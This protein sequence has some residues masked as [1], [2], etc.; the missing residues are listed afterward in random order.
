MHTL[1]HADA[2]RARR[3]RHG[4]LLDRALHRGAHLQPVRHRQ[5]AQLADR[6]TDSEASAPLAQRLV[7]RALQVGQSAHLV[8]H[9][10]PAHHCRAELE[11]HHGHPGAS[12]R[13]RH[14][15]AAESVRNDAR[16]E[17]RHH[18][19]RHSHGVHAAALV[20]QEG[21][22]ARIRLHNVQLNRRDLLV[23]VAVSP[24]SQANRAHS[25]QPGI[26]VQMVLVPLRVVCVL[27][28][29]AHRVRL[30]ACA[31]LD[32]SRPRRHS[33]HSRRALLRH[34]DAHAAQVR[35]DSADAFERLQMVASV[36]ALA[37]AAG[38]LDEPAELLWQECGHHSRVAN[39]SGQQHRRP[40]SQS[41]G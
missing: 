35:H 11:H 6:R 22:A 26:R 18:R 4:P 27:R 17:H 21:H 28:L 15:L 32:R 37:A 3:R 7:P 16:L 10:L 41:G 25:W 1:V 31:A 23:A 24:L 19:D 20:A 13:H 8:P 39:R 29:A 5:G 36:D 2:A 40:K 12:V 33:D 14:H 30:G 38:R 34:A 9:R